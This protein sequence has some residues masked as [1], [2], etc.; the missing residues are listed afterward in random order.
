MIE[1]PM[2]RDGSKFTPSLQRSSGYCVG[3]K[4]A[5]QIVPNFEDALC[6]LREMAV[7][8]WRRPNRA[9]NWGIVTAVEWVELELNEEGLSAIH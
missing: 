9:G 1:V 3:N 5:E 7:A 6:V 8:R 4:G 2:A